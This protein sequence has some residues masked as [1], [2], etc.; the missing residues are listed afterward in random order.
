MDLTT[1][2]N[3]RKQCHNP[4]PNILANIVYILSIALNKVIF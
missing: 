2:H 4:L 3:Y 1:I